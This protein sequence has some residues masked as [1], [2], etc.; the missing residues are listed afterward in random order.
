M[1]YGAKEEEEEGIFGTNYGWK[2]S[3]GTLRAPI[4]FKNYYFTDL[5]YLARFKSY[6]NEKYQLDFL[7]SNLNNYNQFLREF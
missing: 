5:M 1:T 2:E 6:E 4:G 7:R 3:E